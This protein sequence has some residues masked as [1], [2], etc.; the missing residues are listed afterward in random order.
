MTVDITLKVPDRLY[1]RIE[2]VANA[3][4]R[5]ISDVVLEAVERSFP[6]FYVDESRTQLEREVAAF[7]AMHAELWTHYPQQYVA[8]YEGRVI[9]HDD[10]EVALLDRI[11]ARYPGQVVLVRQVLIQ[12]QGE[13]NFRSPRFVRA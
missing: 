5:T 4:R 12:P 6:V 7:E 2:Q 11:D 9:D 3:T 1:R 10:D 8:L 13:L